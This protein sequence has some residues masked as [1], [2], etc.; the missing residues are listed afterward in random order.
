MLI[1]IDLGDLRRVH[2]YI[3]YITLQRI[4]IMSNKHDWSQEFLA[5]QSLTRKLIYLF[6]MP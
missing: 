1:I 5:I 2:H 4:F 6:I 3:R